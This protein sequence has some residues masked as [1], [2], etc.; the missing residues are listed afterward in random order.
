VLL[1][2]SAVYHSLNCKYFGKLISLGNIQ[3]P[4]LLPNAT[5]FQ[6]GTPPPKKVETIT[7]TP[8]TAT[9]V[10]IRFPSRQSRLLHLPPEA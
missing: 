3:L 9:K 7:K 5:F 8:A 4:L 2:Y 1:H 10:K 6:H